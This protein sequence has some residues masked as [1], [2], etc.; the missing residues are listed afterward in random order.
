MIKVT[1]NIAF[2]IAVSLVAFG[3]EA[4]AVPQLTAYSIEIDEGNATEV[5][6]YE[7]FL[8]AAA[9][10][11]ITLD[12]S[13]NGVTAETGDDFELAQGTLEI[14]KGATT[15]SIPITIN[16][17]ET[18]EDT[19][20]FWISFSNPVNVTIPEP[21]ASITLLNDD[22]APPIEDIGYT[23]PTSYP[24]KTLVWEEDFSGTDLNLADWNYETGAS[25]WGNNESQ[26]YRGGDRNAELDQGYLRITAKEET[27]LGA[28]YTSARITTQGKQSFKYG[29]ID[30]RAKVPYGPGIWPALWMLGDNFSTDGWPSCG[31]IDVMELI[32]GDGYNDRTVYGTAHWSNN[33]SHAEHSGNNSLI[34]GKYNDEFHV[35]S[36]VWDSGSIKWYR[37]DVQYHTLSISNL[38]AFKK[39]FF[40]ILNIAVEGNWPGP[41]GPSTTFPQYMLVDYIRVFQ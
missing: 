16:G 6:N 9:A 33:G 7:V 1:R 39:K 3:C 27:H 17:D 14:P 10:K 25:G 4:P 32:G 40:F 23:T 15:A 37:D 34:S 20:S 36:I 29:R 35:F 41:V 8:S 21:F 12:Y 28:P 22:G 38:G 13:T 5:I 2:S 31:E 30:I 26:Y 11:T 18:P 19:E 24:G